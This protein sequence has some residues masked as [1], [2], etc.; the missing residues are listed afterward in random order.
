MS[1]DSKLKKRLLAGAAACGAIAL[2]LSQFLTTGAIDCTPDA[3]R[4]RDVDFWDR[5]AA[6]LRIDE[7][8]GGTSPKR[9]A[10]ECSALTVA[11]A[12]CT[13]TLDS[14]FSKTLELC[15]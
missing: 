9:P 6:C 13:K 1:P 2:A 4:R 8:C 10:A 11:A 3:R 5:F 14:E 7:G 15:K 12:D